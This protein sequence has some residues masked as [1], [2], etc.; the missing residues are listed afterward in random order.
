MPYSR[1]T[2]S[3]LRTMVAQDIQAE[4]PGTD[5]L[6]RYSSLGIMGRVLA[7]L[8]NLFYGF[9]DWISRQAVPFTATDEYLEGWAALK[10]VFREAAAVASG[11]ITFTG[12]AGA[13]IAAGA[14][15]TRGDGVGA[16]VTVGGTVGAGGTVTVTAQ[17]N[18][19]PSGQRGA[20]GN[21]PVG[22]QFTLG[23]AIDGIASVGTAATAFTGGADIELDDS[24]RGRMLLAYQTTPQGG[25]S[26][27]YVE[28]AREVSGV[29][30]AWCTPNGMGPGTVVVRFM[31]DVSEAASGGFPQGTNGVAAA[32]ARDTAA[33]GDQLAVAN[34]IFSKQPVTA[35][36]YSVAPGANTV[37]FMIS[38]LT[39]AS[40]ALQ[41][42]IAAA[43]TGVFEQYGEPGGTID[44][45]YI[46]S[47]ISA[48]AGTPG[49]VITSPAVNIVSPTGELPVLGTVT[50]S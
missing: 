10:G 2:L 14:A 29:T 4:L 32:E 5:P 15:L 8:V 16:V 35:L 22:T 37:N 44:L 47:A 30:R 26:T 13:S 28:W 25:A 49:F 11:T 21:C 19:D 18:A 17:I 33:T 39:G 41:A 20:F 1:P 42:S 38:G 31:M 36:V 45:S 46:E 43:I 40:S 34:Y 23:S 27:D 6:L 3:D 12:N 24:L 48:I 7:G 9:L 50:Y